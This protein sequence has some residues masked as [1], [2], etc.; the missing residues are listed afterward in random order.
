VPY[1]A[2]FLS[3]VDEIRLEAKAP[4]AHD[5][6]PVAALAKQALGTVAV[7]TEQDGEWHFRATAFG[8]DGR[9][10]E[11]AEATTD[12]ERP[13]TVALRAEP[14]GSQRVGVGSEPKRVR[15]ENDGAATLRVRTVT[16][17]GAEFT[18]TRDQCS[19][20]RVAPGGSC[21][22]V[23]T[24][25]PA[26]PGERTA[27]LRV[28]AN[29]PASAIDLHGTG[30][31]SAPTTAPPPVTPS[32]RRAPEV[33]FT[34]NPGPRTTRLDHLRIAHVPSG[35]TVT[36]RCSRGCTRS[37]LTRRNAKGTVSLTSFARKRL[38]AGTTLRITIA[39][40]GRPA[41]VVTLK[42]RAGREPSVVSGG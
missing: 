24:F 28:E 36:A 22:L 31:E 11:T 40:P 19:A 9:V 30:R 20:Q 5:F 39:E 37:S 14:F 16:V 29:A 12:I 1:T 42:V 35:S 25:T 13:T 2:A 6:A 38:R 33:L 27:R 10:L 8:H 23:L 21:D 3:A 7:P 18:L 34:A 15:I 41:V 26:A 17:D 32:A 4:G